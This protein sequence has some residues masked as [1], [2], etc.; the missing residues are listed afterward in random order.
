MMEGAGMREERGD[1]ARLSVIGLGKLGSPMAAV[2]AARGFEV[3]GVDLNPAF[4]QAIND[5]RAPVDEPQLQ[6]YIDTA[7]GRL[8]ATTS[9]DDA[10][11]ASDVTFV[12]VPTPSGPDHFF[13]N[14]HVIE[15]VE[16]IGRALGGTRDDHLVVVT[17]TVTPGSTG[18]P[19]REALERS[20]GRRVGADVGLCYSPEFIAL[21][22]VV[23]DLLH[24][25]L[26]LIGECSPAYG[27]RLERVYQAVT[28]PGP[29][30]HRMSFVN[31]EIC[32]IAVNTFVTT[33]ISYANMLA[34]LCDRLEGADVDVVARA[35][36]ADTRIGGKY[37]RGGVAYGG[38]CF[39]R[40]NKAFAA[41]ARSLGV[42]C[43]I[44]EATDAINDH[45]VHR[46][47]GAVSACVPKGARVAVLGLAYKPHTP[48]VEQSQGLAL[49]RMLRDEGYR[50]IAADPLS[51]AAGPAIL[52]DAVE[53]AADLERAVSAADAVV[54][55]TPWPEIRELP[56]RAFVRPGARL[57]VIDPW[58]LFRDTPIVDAAHVIALGRG[59]WRMPAA[60]GALAESGSRGR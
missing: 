28:G 31:A 37:L 50:V 8:R 45:Q 3:V 1:R 20:S 39:P 2:F 54:V 52:G 12:I 35:L 49:A 19:I 22:S 34:E 26:V 29:S 59:G 25:D 30:V 55:T 44:A 27:S 36:G 33:K 18:G 46:L 23:R 40:D 24:P 21:G 32:K 43:D 57:P 60:V 47:F 38:P 9:V 53:A 5:G 14:A 10:V 56:A 11:R 6:E 51:A 48:V 13:T 17:S 16:R 41:I 42:R 4:V 15:A 58:G 7:A